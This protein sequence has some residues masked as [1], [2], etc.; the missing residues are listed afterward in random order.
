MSVNDRWLISKKQIIVKDVGL[1][2]NGNID[3]DLFFRLL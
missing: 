1:M 2:M 3:F